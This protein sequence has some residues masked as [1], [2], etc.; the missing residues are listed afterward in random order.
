[1][2]YEGKWTRLS[3]QRQFFFSFSNLI[4]HYKMKLR[5]LDEEDET[6]RGWR[7]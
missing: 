2:S 3:N 1:M 4:E 6:E 5:K 7:K